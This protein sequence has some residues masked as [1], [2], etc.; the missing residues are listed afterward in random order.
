MLAGELQRLL[1]QERTF[2]ISLSVF[3]L[4]NSH[5]ESQSP[6]HVEIPVLGDL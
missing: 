2:S 1:V 3:T 6:D 5:V 4:L